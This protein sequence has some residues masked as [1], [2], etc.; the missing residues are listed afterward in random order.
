MT[1]LYLFFLTGS[2]R[3]NVARCSHKIEMKENTEKIKIE[4]GSQIVWPEN[5]GNVWTVDVLNSQTKQFEAYLNGDINAAARFD[6]N[7][8]E[9]AVLLNN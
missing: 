5:P 6:F 1:A 9:N 4:I 2:S 3:G 8:L 7:Q